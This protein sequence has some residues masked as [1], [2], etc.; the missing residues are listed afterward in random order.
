MHVHIS[1]RL[2]T[3]RHHEIAPSAQTGISPK[4]LLECLA[5]GDQIVEVQG[6]VPQPRFLRQPSSQLPRGLQHEDAA[7]ITVVLLGHAHWPQAGAQGPSAS[8]S[9]GA[10]PEP[11]A[12][13]SVWATRA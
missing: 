5:I 4:P 1:R 10:L 6:P 7:I 3:V 8:R 9:C 13:S 2:L 12:G 11:E